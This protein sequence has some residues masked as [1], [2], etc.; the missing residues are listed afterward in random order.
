MKNSY[1][2]LIWDWNGTLFDDLSLCVDIMNGIL[3][4]NSLKEI[5]VEHY[6]NIFTFPVKEYYRRTGLNFDETDFLELG[7]EFMDEY[8]H[9]KLTARLHKGGNEI[10]SYFSNKGIT[11]SILSAYSQ[12]TLI[13][14]VKYFNIEKHF[15]GIIGLDNIYAES[16]ME[17]GQKWINSLTLPPNEIL[18]I[19]DTVHDFEVARENGIDC[20]LIANGHQSKEKLAVCDT[21]VLD[22]LSDIYTLL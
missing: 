21:I 12:H 2:H 1:S 11:Q 4:R 6:R 19:G 22:E 20:L 14:L 16:K 15:L 18:F 5:S 17:L 13:E 8:E 10:L 3:R 9:K 7:R